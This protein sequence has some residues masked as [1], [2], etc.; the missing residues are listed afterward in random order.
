MAE[1]DKV[2]DL[3]DN[4][5]SMLQSAAYHELK[6]LSRGMIVT[7]LT[8]QEPSMMMQTVNLHLRDNLSWTTTPEGAD[9][10]RTVVTHREDVAASDVIDLLTR[11][12]KR[13]DDLFARALHYV[14]AGNVADAAPLMKEFS[15]GLKR[16][17]DVENNILALSF[18]APRE[19]FGG[20]PTSTM[21]R[22]HDEIQM[23]ATVIESYFD[24]GLPDAKEVSAFFAI[25]SGTLAKHEFREESILFPHWSAAIHRAPAE[26]QL[27]LFKKVQAT[28]AGIAELKA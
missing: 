17:V 20:D 15:E 9:R 4:P 14:N 23:H 18:A 24:E 13:L 16:H 25:L 5:S 19:Q 28:L 21:L 1:T 2:L 11:D 3:T 26:A 10:W 22:E 27:D 8:A 6:S 7:L 12:H